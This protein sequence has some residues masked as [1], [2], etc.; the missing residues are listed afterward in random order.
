MKNEILYRGFENIPSRRGRG[1]VYQYIRWQDIADRMNEAFGTSWSSEVTFQDIVGSNVIVRVR[2]TVFDKSTETFSKQEG[3]GGA[4]NEEQSEAGNPFKSAYSKALKDACKKWGVGLFLE[5]DD[6]A[7][8]QKASPSIPNGYGGMEQG[9]PGGVSATPNTGLPLPTPPSSGGMPM[10]PGASMA[11]PGTVVQESVGVQQAPPAQARQQQPVPPAMPTSQGEI[12]TPPGISLKED[13]PMS[14]VGTIDTGE[15]LVSDV[16][17]AAI[18]GILAMP[19]VTIAYEE[20]AKQA[21][22]FNGVDKKSVP[23]IDD[24]T[25]QE[26]VYVVKYGNDQFRKR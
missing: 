21:F 10:P 26:A 18:K 17:K 2:V 1:G 11:K 13:M 5:L 15:D 22:E 3:F 4:P 25:Y 8:E 16:Q 19:T 24:L 14:K 12:P 23:A 6:E 9:I 7:G 20:L